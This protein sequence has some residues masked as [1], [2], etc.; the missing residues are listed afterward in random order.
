MRAF[1]SSVVAALIIAVIAVYVLDSAQQTVDQ[2]F[3]SPTTVRYP[4][5]K[6]ST[7]LS[8][9]IGTTPRSTDA[10]NAGAIRGAQLR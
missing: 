10:E 6:I 7:I 5:R 1:V 4:M 2:S 3:S 8:V 9:R